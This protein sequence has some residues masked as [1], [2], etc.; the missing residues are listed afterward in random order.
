MRR[1]VNTPT[2]QMVRGVVEWVAGMRRNGLITGPAGLGKT[3]ALREAANQDRRAVFVTA[4]PAQKSLRGT[5]IMV[6][7]AFGYS[8]HNE[9]TASMHQ[10]L[11]SHLPGRAREGRYLIVDEA[12]ILPADG[13]RQILVYSDHHEDPLPVIFAGNEYALKKTRANAA[14]FDQIISRMAM[15]RQIAGI[16]SGDIDAFCGR[17]ECRRARRLRRHASLRRGQELPRA[18]RASERCA[19]PGRC[20]GIDQAASHQGRACG[21]LRA[22]AGEAA[23]R[24]D[25]GSVTMKRYRDFNLSQLS[26]SQL[27]D[28]CYLFIDVNNAFGGTLWR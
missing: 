3:H 15:R 24:R 17:L 13:M 25:G 14:A 6:L 5:M 28:F 22:G 12:Q 16:T 27:E 21:S 1:Y 26:R 19:Q 11:A 7:E 8:S 4:T 10:V 2:G 9:T 20:E 23:R 18:G